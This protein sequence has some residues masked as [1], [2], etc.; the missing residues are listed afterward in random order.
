MIRKK[1]IMIRL[2]EAETDIEFIYHQMDLLEKRIKKLEPKKERVK[3]DVK[4]SK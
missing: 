4:V 1:E 3:K 2:C